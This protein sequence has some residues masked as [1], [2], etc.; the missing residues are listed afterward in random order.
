MD[1]YGKTYVIRPGKT[2]CLCGS[3]VHNSVENV[4]N[5]LVANKK[6]EIMV[7]LF[8]MAEG[9]QAGRVRCFT[10]YAEAGYVAAVRTQ[11]D[12]AQVF[13]RLCSSQVGAG[14][15]PPEG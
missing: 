14:L 3:V 12:W 11:K 15:D 5:L 6:R 4:N 2:L 7:N 1:L 10:G 13:C 8:A 9:L